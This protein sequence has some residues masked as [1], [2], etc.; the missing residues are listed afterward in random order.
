MVD[1]MVKG[2]FVQFLI[3]FLG[4]GEHKNGTIS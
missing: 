4:N 2:L 3:V 1:F